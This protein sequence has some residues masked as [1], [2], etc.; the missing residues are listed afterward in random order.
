MIYYYFGG[1]DGLYVRRAGE[2][3]PEHPRDRGR[4]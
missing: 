2:G 4:R 1:K 3:L